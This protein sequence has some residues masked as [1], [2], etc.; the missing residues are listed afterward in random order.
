M[1]AI[2]LDTPIGEG[3]WLGPKKQALSNNGLFGPISRGWPKVLKVAILA[4][5]AFLGPFGIKQGTDGDPK[6]GIY[7]YGKRPF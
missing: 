4:I 2:I 5:L 3:P 6:M 7:R 1:I